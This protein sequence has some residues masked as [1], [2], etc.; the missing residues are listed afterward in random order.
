MISVWHNMAEGENP[1][2]S[3][4]DAM[5]DL[6]DKEGVRVVCKILLQRVNKAATAAATTAVVV[7]R[8]TT[9]IVP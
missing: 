8:I 9:A 6:C 7:I 1:P 4:R 3:S 2:S 5:N